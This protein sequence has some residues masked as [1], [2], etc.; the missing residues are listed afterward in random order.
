MSSKGDQELELYLKD[1][2]YVQD[3]NLI[4][5]TIFDSTMYGSKQY[6]WTSGW[7]D[8]L[9]KFWQQF[10]RFE[11]NAKLPSLFSFIC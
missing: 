6:L 10:G 7:V 11:I 5:R 2:V 8:T 4:L 3:D 1:N 9:H